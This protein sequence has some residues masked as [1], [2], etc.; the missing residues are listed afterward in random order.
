MCMYSTCVSKRKAK[1]I[2]KQNRKIRGRQ[3]MARRAITYMCDR[4][5]VRFEEWAA[6]HFSKIMF[7]EKIANRK[8]KGFCEC[9]AQVELTQVRSGRK[10]ECPSCKEQTLLKDWK[11]NKTIAQQNYFSL[12]ERESDGLIQR[13]FVAEKETVF[14]GVRSDVSIAYKEEQRDYMYYDT[15][16]FTFHPVFGC[17]SNDWRLGRGRMHGTGWTG[18]RIAEKPLHL[19]PHNLDRILNG[20]PF[21]YSALGIAARK[22]LVEPFYYLQAEKKEPKLEL[23]V[24]AGL[25]S[26]ARQVL[27]DGWY[28]DVERARNYLSDKV[29]SLKDLGIDDASELEEC[30]ALTVQELIARKEI[31]KWKIEQGAR[32]V[33]MEFIKTLNYRSGED[34]V[35][36]FLSRQGLFKYWLTQQEQYPS[37]SDFLHD[38][39]D[40]ISDARTLGCNLNDTK[41]SKPRNFKVMH[42]WAMSEVKITK[43]QVFDAQILALYNAI[44]TLCEWSDKTYSIVMPST[45]REIVQEG[46]NQ[47]HCVGRY[48]ERV[49][50][51]ESIILF[52]RRKDAPDQS[53]YTMEIK[54]DMNRLDI[55]QCR[56][57]DN[58]DRNEKEAAEIERVKVKYTEWFN[59]RSTNGYQSEIMATY[60]KAVRKKNGKYISNYDD[61]TEYVVGEE[62]SVKTDTNPDSV[63]VKGL[64][65][66]SLEFAKRFGAGWKDVAILEVKANI[67]DVIVPDA[68]DQVRVTRLKVVRE[69]PF[70]E[71]GEWGRRRLETKIA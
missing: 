43:K 58:Q 49:A 45:S 35:Y 2:E 57:Y 41:I 1:S 65:V 20:T 24:K 13:L 56:G 64:H 70:E 8:Y 33:A 16:R 59:H 54:P 32:A 9:G 38:Y 66:A 26:V 69:V 31:K 30:R 10:I 23:L 25:I 61:K 19:Y 28:S 3:A 7:Y 4:L 11:R 52:V 5:P 21:Q 55:V 36:S 44:H 37:A 14:D 53:W 12:L 71:L 17:N 18:W 63:A 40:Y 29:K 48:C 62:M 68:L 6:E 15:E 50:R 67:H 27:G 39:T 51:A 60:Y 46:V 42:D 22:L 34:F 47:S